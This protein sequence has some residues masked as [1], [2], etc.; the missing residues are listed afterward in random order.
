MPTHVA[1][2]RGINLGPHKRVAMPALRA[3]VESLGHT[4]VATYIA[5]GNVVFTAGDDAAPGP[6][7]EKAIA[8]EL[9]VELDYVYQDRRP[10][11]VPI[12]I[13]A[14]G[15]QMMQLAGEIADGV[16]LNY[17]VD[18]AYNIAA[19]EALARGAAKAARSVDDLDRPQLV[20][21]SVDEDRQQS[22]VGPYHK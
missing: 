22:P 9:G 12:Y 11:N 17:L 8:A 5:S 19:M 21:C 4:E 10:K 6:G 16:V 13:G 20:I 3:L 7:L 1:L 14:T 18:P 2:L 15:M